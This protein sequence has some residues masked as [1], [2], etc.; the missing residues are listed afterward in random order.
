MTCQVCRSKSQPVFSVRVVGSEVNCTRGTRRYLT[1]AL[2]RFCLACLTNGEHTFQGRA[3]S[4]SV[5]KA[6]HLPGDV[7]TRS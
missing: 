5:S 6:A 7:R 2:G 4:V 1:L 3:V